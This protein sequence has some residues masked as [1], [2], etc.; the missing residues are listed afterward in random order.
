MRF[1]PFKLNVYLLSPLFFYG[2][3]T[4]HVSYYS[5]ITLLPPKIIPHT[6]IPPS[7]LSFCPHRCKSWMYVRLGVFSLPLRPPPFLYQLQHSSQPASVAVCLL[8]ALLSLSVLG[9]RRVGWN[10]LALE[11]TIITVSQLFD[12]YLNITS[13]PLARLPGMS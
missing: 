1:F 6:N 13:A 3:S 11:C 10:P 12:L 7:G 4:P 2:L 9:M 5:N 8:T